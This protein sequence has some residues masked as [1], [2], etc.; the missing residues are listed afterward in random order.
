METKR[1]IDFRVIN[2]CFPDGQTFQGAIL[3]QHATLRD[4]IEETISRLERDR[5][6]EIIYHEG[7]FTESLNFKIVDSYSGL[8][9]RLDL[10]LEH[11]EFIL[12]A[13]RTKRNI[14][15]DIDG[16]IFQ[17]FQPTEI[18]D[19]SPVVLEIPTIPLR[20][21]SK[22]NPLFWSKNEITVLAGLPLNAPISRTNSP[23][24]LVSPSSDQLHGD[25][26]NFGTL[27]DAQKYL[28]DYGL[29]KLP[30]YQFE[31]QSDST[32]QISLSSSGE[33]SVSNSTN[34]IRSVCTSPDF[35]PP[36]INS[37]TNGEKKLGENKP[38]S[39][40]IFSKI[41][42]NCPK[43]VNT[44]T[45]FIA[46]EY[47]VKFFLP[48]RGR[49]LIFY[50]ESYGSQKVGELMD[51]LVEIISQNE[52]LTPNGEIFCH[53][54][55]DNKFDLSYKIGDSFYEIV[56]YEE[57]VSNL[58]CSS[59]GQENEKPV[60]IYLI[61]TSAF[62][63][64]DRRSELKI[65]FLISF[66]GC[67]IDLTKS[68]AVRFA[69]RTFSYVKMRVL[70]ERDPMYFAMPANIN[71]DIKKIDIKNNIRF[72]KIYKESVTKVLQA[73]VT[74][75]SPD[76]L[77]EEMFEKLCLDQ[78]TSKNFALRTFNR[79][80]YF[81]GEKALIYFTALR[82]MLINNQELI[83]LIVTPKLV[84]DKM[85]SFKD[86]SH[87]KTVLPENAQISSASAEKYQ[88]SEIIQ[89][90]IIRLKNLFRIRICGIENMHSWPSS[91]TTVF[92]RASLMHGG[93]ELSKPIT[94]NRVNIRNKIKWNEWFYFDTSVRNLPREAR[95]HIKLLGCDEKEH[96]YPGIYSQTGVHPLQAVNFHVIDHTGALQTGLKRL[97]L[98]PSMELGNI[99]KNSEIYNSYGVRCGINLSGEGSTSQNPESNKS[100][101]FIFKLDEYS[102]PVISSNG[103]DGFFDESM[104]TELDPGSES[105][106]IEKIIAREH[107][108]N[109]TYNEKTLILKFSYY[110]SQIPNAL[111]KYLFC[112]NWSNPESVDECH[113][114]IK[115]WCPITLEIA[116]T[117]LDHRFADLEVR[118]LA[119]TYLEG[120][121]NDELQ[122]Y[123]LQL[124]QVIKFE[125]FHDSPLAR[126]LVDRALRCR[127]I[128]HYFFWLLRS[129]IGTPEYQ[130]RYAVI[131]EAFLRGCDSDILS[132]LTS[133]VK[134]ITST[135]ELYKRVWCEVEDFDNIVRI[136]EFICS[137]ISKIQVEEN[138]C[139]I[140]DPMIEVRKID[141]KLIKIMNSKKKPIWLEFKN[142]DPHSNLDHIK[143]LVKVGDDL[144]QDMLTLQ[145]LK[146]MDKLWLQNGLDLHLTIYGC[147]STGID[148]GIIEIVQNAK[149]VC[150]IQKEA[151]VN[152][153]ETF[154]KEV[155]LEWLQK[156]NP[157]ESLLQKARENFLY[158]CAGYCV[159]TYI[160]GIG[161][162]HN[163][164]IMLTEDGNLFHIDFGHFLGNKKKKY[165]INREPVP[166]ILT[167][168]FIHVLGGI[169]SETYA[170]FLKIAIQAYHII[171][172]HATLFTTLFSMMKSTGLPELRG[173]S[174]LAYLHESL[175]QDS[176][177]AQASNHFMSL[178]QKSIENSLKVQIHWE[179]H[180]LLKASSVKSE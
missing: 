141:E 73:D 39:I 180:L 164:N 63:N 85:E 74:L 27:I 22:V 151:K 42:H 126:F 51:R 72:F 18:I 109:L 88:H 118:K 45:Y 98:W 10:E 23:T 116:L 40:K 154:Q 71:M 99:D 107:F 54:E 125:A 92:V 174:D 65:R 19:N 128:C 176:T 175:K 70:R 102:H 173:D 57:I 167:P 55:S 179:I 60:E 7:L 91:I 80:E 29:V 53:S 87:A 111:P 52:M 115:R 2:L 121:E 6:V 26:S 21:E 156:K 84:E 83:D 35:S 38:T 36:G 17:T 79:R 47:M 44:S 64:E 172:R 165:L 142:N 28:L 89:I 127:I 32:S 59:S 110:C 133:Q 3:P 12:D 123:L 67:Q 62:P 140:Y 169:G 1:D 177:D 69:R 24:N 117:L 96:D 5:K 119:V 78:G 93:T 90:P 41:S 147:L 14:E 135:V 178:V 43:D 112:I 66:G 134:F 81:Y 136:K 97:N 129:E 33:S 95:I 155:L 100:A 152:I 76:M 163:D 131:L 11:D 168:D 46:N 144:R 8:S 157:T 106:A 122:L 20:V 31:S 158:S 108:T 49:T 138:F 159:A 86:A 82:R 162:R 139:P 149:T 50:L 56:D 160:L 120:L 166:F 94:T 137:N 103:N 13:F 170:N 148:E 153:L 48:Y 37:P 9:V 114:L 104:V 124:I 101:V 4:F 132:S 145:M 34:P 77:L 130:E 146:L 30:V 113:Y 105:E 143:I 61:Q 150:N 171:R 58:K 15:L 25:N 161:D 16:D 68:N 75:V